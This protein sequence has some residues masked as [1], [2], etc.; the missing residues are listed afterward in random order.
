MNDTIRTIC[1]TLVL[2]F[3][4]PHAVL[5]DEGARPLPNFDAVPKDDAGPD[6]DAI[7][8]II[9][10][11]RHRAPRGDADAQV[12]L[13]EHYEDGDGV[14]QNYGKAAGW[15]ERAADQGNARAQNRLG[16]LYLRG[17]GV[18]QDYS[19]AYFWITIS[20]SPLDK[21]TVAIREEIKMALPPEK[22]SALQ[23][24]I[25]EWAPEVEDVDPLDA[26]DE[27]DETVDEQDVADENLCKGYDIAG[28]TAPLPRRSPRPCR[29]AYNAMQSACFNI[30][31]CVDC[32]T[33]LKSFIVAC[34][35]TTTAQDANPAYACD[36][37]SDCHLI[38]TNYCEVTYEPLS[39]NV[40]HL[41]EVRRARAIPV[42]DC[43]RPPELRAKYRAICTDHMCQVQ[44]L[45]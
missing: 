28:R 7:A 38:E 24:R 32:E 18:P 40:Q 30:T 14:K 1:L 27:Q 31:S 16:Y 43:P 33:A 44:K 13:G 21:K 23:K 39:V 45:E 11:L 15:Y 3:W 9:K 20:A 17:L 22:L 5:A 8:V 34:R 42:I 19:E 12:L 10:D 36:A 6:K 41:Q 29:A 35:K 2:G 26:A 4:L 25:V 37:D